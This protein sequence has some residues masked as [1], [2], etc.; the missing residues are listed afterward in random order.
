MG[1][2]NA[3]AAQRGRSFSFPRVH[4]FSLAE[5]AI[6]LLVLA[7][8]LGGL[9]LPWA[10]QTEQE[11][12]AET[13]QRIETVKRALIG[14]A[15]ANCPAGGSGSSMTKCLP[16]PS[17]RPNPDDPNNIGKWNEANGEEDCPATEGLVPWTTLGLSKGDAVDAWYRPLRYR[18]LEKAVTNSNDDIDHSGSTCHPPSPPPNKKPPITVCRIPA[19]GGGTLQHETNYVVALILSHGPNGRG[20]Y[21]SAVTLAPQPGEWEYENTNR[22]LLYLVGTP[23]DKGVPNN[24]PFDDVVGW[25]SAYELCKEA[26]GGCQYYK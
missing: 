12:I 19:N 3:W 20:A 7:F 23:T 18:V 1:T 8:A 25:I 4:G 11:K 16:C 9:L 5:L 14:Y 24:N 15:A 10:T 6:V 21:Y 13:K 22:D 17:R 2:A 26:P